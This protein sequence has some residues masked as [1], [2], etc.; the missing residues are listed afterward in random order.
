VNRRSA[1][2]PPTK[3]LETVMK[4]LRATPPAVIWAAAAV[5]LAMHFAAGSAA[6]QWVRGSEQFYLPA[7][8]NWVFRQNY[9]GADRL[10]NAFDYG[11]AILYETL[12]RYPEGPV[13][14]LEEGHFRFLTERLLKRPPRVALEEGAVQIGYSRLA[15]EAKLMFE[16]AHV[17]HRQLYDVLADERLSPEEKDAAIAELLAYYRSRPDLAFSSVPKS[18]DIMDGQYYSLAF[19]ERY[20]K[21]NGLI[22]AYHWLQVGLYEPLLIHDEVAGRTAGVTATVGRFWQ[23]L[24][25]A[26]ETMPYLMPMTAGVAPT[27]AARYP[28]AAVIFDNLHMMHDVVSDILASPQV[29]RNRKRA[30]ILA[31]AERFRDDSSY[32]ISLEEWAAMGEMMGLNN[33][34]GRAIGFTA[35]L[36]RPTVER[37]ASMAGMDHSRSHAAD[38]TPAVPARD[39]TQRLVELQTRLLADPEIRDRVV[40][41][42]ELRVMVEEVERAIAAGTAVAGSAASA[43]EELLR[44]VLADPRVEARLHAEP[45]LHELWDDPEV[46]RVLAAPAGGSDPMHQH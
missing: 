34:G 38:S 41:D 7:S 12:Y 42:P 26:P 5:A 25:S 16:W 43:L 37:G 19:R 11:H 18:M 29:P 9:I 8:H 14:R 44:R 10:F 46:Q 21:F 6:G 40:G 31:A 2:E 24:E 3:Y 32:A 15:P 17:F 28:E 36:P 1:R 27:F 23:M 39:V 13:E 45:G 33:M 20:P 35:D 4:A 30:E 22:W